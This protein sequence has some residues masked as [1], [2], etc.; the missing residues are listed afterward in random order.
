MEYFEW[1][2]SKC[3]RKYGPESDEMADVY[4]R[5][6]NMYYINGVYGKALYY[7]RLAL[8]IE[9]SIHGSNNLLTSRYKRAAEICIAWQYYGQTL[10]YGIKAY[11]AII[12]FAGRGVHADETRSVIYDAY[13]NFGMPQ[14]LFSDWLA[15]ECLRI[16]RQLPPK[17][18]GKH[19]RG[20]NARNAAYQGDGNAV[21]RL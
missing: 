14:A 5:M 7:C 19:H 10:K 1:S 20:R 3:K 12:R 15:G 17:P 11:R 18:V 9:K 2:I 6:A 4:E 8:S 16:N 13:I 21:T